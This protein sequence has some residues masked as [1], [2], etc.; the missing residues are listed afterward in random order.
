MGHLG[1]LD[2]YAQR[3]PKSRY[4]PPNA[5]MAA[6]IDAVVEL[7]RKW[8][9]AEQAYKA[10]LAALA[11]PQPGDPE[12]VPINHIA[13]RLGTVRKTVYRHLGRSMS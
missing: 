5:E 11:A 10:A 7:H 9:E 2:R 6:R 4:T 1:T 3:V 8:G 13:E 12:H